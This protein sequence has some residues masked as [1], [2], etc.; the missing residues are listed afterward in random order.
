MQKPSV[1]LINCGN[2]WEQLKK[3]LTIT[4]FRNLKTV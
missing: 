4:L 3:M 2:Y 1:Q